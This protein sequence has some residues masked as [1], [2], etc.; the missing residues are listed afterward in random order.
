MAL[1]VLCIPDRTLS[2]AN[3]GLAFLE[4]DE[5][6]NIREHADRDEM[7]FQDK[8]IDE[9][10]SVLQKME[11]DF[12]ENEEE[13]FYPDLF[14][15]ILNPQRHSTSPAQHRSRPI[16]FQDQKIRFTGLG[17]DEEYVR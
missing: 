2:F 10:Q 13:H 12:V 3:S 5:L 6:V 9:G 4:H 8:H 15:T 16:S 17:E 1:T 11:I 14:D 7:L